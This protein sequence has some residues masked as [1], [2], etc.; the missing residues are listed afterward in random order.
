VP[1]AE[2]QAAARRAFADDLS[3]FSRGT[4]GSAVF[5]DPK[6]AGDG[7][8]DDDDAETTA[9]TATAEQANS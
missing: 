2:Q 8:E 9:T 1:T 4:G 7:E 5:A 6:A 3:A